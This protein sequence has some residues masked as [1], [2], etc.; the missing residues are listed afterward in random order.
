V[1]L[2]I[3]K[4]R[5]AQTIF[6]A[7]CKRLFTASCRP[8]SCFTLSTRRLKTSARTEYYLS[9]QIEMESVVVSAPC[10]R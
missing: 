1:P 10:V 9:T 7:G 8:G 4:G 5:K 2:K 6:I 3:S